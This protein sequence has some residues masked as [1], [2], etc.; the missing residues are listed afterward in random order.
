MEEKENFYK[1]LL[2]M[3]PNGIIIIDHKSNILFTNSKALK[4]LDVNNENLREK[5]LSF[6]A[7]FDESE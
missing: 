7:L 6:D 5:I 3:Q 1:G 2:D 4:L